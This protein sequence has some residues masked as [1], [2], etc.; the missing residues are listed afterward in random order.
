M[1]GKHADIVSIV[2][3][4]SPAW[5]PK[6]FKKYDVDVVKEKIRWVKESAI[7]HGRD[8]ESIE[9]A[10]F[11]PRDVLVSDDVSD[12]VEMKS[13]RYGISRDEYLICQVLLLDLVRRLGRNLL[14]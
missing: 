2:P 12:Q 6:E 1:A 4:Q 14:T 9:F 5:P 10:L 7:K 11:S 8:P 3:K 13:K